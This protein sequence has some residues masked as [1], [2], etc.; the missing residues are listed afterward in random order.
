MKLDSTVFG[1][2]TGSPEPSKFKPMAMVTSSGE[3]PSGTLIVAVVSVECPFVVCA[4]SAS[5]IRVHPV[6]LPV[7]AGGTP[8]TDRLK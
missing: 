4:P 5:L 2:A 8:P 3:P 1:L 6:L 7:L